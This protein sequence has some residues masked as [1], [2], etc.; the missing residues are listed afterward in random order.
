MCRRTSLF[1]PQ[2]DIERRL[3]AQF[4]HSWP[5]QYNIAPQERLATV[6]NDAPEEIDQLE[7]GLIPHWVDDPDDGPKPINAWAETVAEKPYFRDAFDKR[8]CLVL[9]DGFYEWNGE[10][11][12]KQPYRVQRNDV[13]IYV[14]AGLWET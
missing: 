12:H 3:D 4:I 6:W 10:R 1:V 7:W 2:Q 11:G 8:R 13:G 9:A 14:Y 5:P